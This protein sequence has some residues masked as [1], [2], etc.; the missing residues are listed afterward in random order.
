MPHPSSFLRPHLRASR[1]CAATRHGIRYPQQVIL[2]LLPTSC[3]QTGVHT[4]A[5][6]PVLPTAMHGRHVSVCWPDHLHGRRTAGSHRLQAVPDTEGVAATA[7]SVY[8]RHAERQ[9][10]KVCLCSWHGSIIM[11][12]AAYLTCPAQQPARW[13]SRGAVRKAISSTHMWVL[14]SMFGSKQHALWSER[15]ARAE[16]HMLHMT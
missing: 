16:H 1:A 2:R 10:G 6:V 14:A 4:L 7:A 11:K 12:P 8:V 15:S 5:S 9:A 13:T 3:W